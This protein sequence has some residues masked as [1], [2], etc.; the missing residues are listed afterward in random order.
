MAKIVDITE[1]LNFEQKPQIKIKNEILTVNNEA[2]AILKIMPLLDMEKPSLA[3]VDKVCRTLFDETDFE[4]I[5]K[6]HLSF[7]DFATLTT[8][9]ISLVT[10]GSSGEVVTHATT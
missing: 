2:A 1:R 4:K 10:G 6:L 7:E 8:T 9:A 3:S 5:E